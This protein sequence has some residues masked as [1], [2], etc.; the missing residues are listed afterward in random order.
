MTTTTTRPTKT[1][2]LPKAA[3]APKPE[4]K[5]ENHR[6]RTSRIGREIGGLAVNVYER[7]IADV[8]AFEKDAAKITPYPWAKEALTVSAGLIED[9]GAAYVRTARHILR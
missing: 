6:E 1:T 2:E 3:T 5:A 7:G 4:K 9:V 8:V